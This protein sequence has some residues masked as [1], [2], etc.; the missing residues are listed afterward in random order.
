MVESNSDYNRLSYGNEE[1]PLLNEERRDAAELGKSLPLDPAV[2]KAFKERRRDQDLE[3]AKEG[4]RLMLS[5]SLS[6]PSV[7]FAYFSTNGGLTDGPETGGGNLT[8]GRDFLA[9]H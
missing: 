6:K 8:K 2:V 3:R 9:M 4:G 5:R 7:G 1:S